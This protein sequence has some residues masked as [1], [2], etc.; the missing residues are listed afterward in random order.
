MTSLS[1]KRDVQDALVNYL[2]GIGWEYLPPDEVLRLRGGDLREPFLIPLAR[3]QLIALNAP[4]SPSAGPDLVTA[5]DIDNVLRRLR[6]VHPSLAGNED[7]LHYLRGHR[8]VYS[9]AEKRGSATWR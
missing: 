9:K 2:I 8:T 4:A 5:E 3:E 7:F 1:E 6:T